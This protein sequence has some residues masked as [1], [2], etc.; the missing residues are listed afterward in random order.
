[1]T[2]ATRPVFA[3]ARA[4]H[5]V[6]LPSARPLVLLVQAR[7]PPTHL[8]RVGEMPPKRKAKAPSEAKPKKAAAASGSSATSRGKPGG[9][10][11]GGLG[12]GM[13][14]KDPMAISFGDSDRVES[15]SF[16]ALDHHVRE[17]TSPFA[18]PISARWGCAAGGDAFAFA[19]GCGRVRSGR[20]RPLFRWGMDT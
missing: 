10:G 9:G 19:Q 5:R 16:I 14:L 12:G 4:P 18:C 6:E 1:M 11:L 13:K 20:E 7:R 8:G 3:A 15:V 2:T 17:S